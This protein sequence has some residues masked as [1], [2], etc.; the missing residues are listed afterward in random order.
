MCPCKQL[1]FTLMEVLVAVAI[2][3]VI[4]LGAWQVISSVVNSR[5]RV[6]Q[7]AGQFDGLQTAMLLLERDLAQIVN[8]PVRDTYGDVQPALTTRE[9]GFALIL[10]RQGW[11]NPL[12]LR[13]SDLQ[14]AGWEYTGNELSR[15]YWPMVDQGQEEQGRAVVLLNQVTAFEIRFLDSGGR[16]YQQ[17]PK[18]GVVAGQLPGGRPDTPLPLGIEVTLEHEQFGAITRTFALPDFHRRRGQ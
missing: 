2:T 14:R 4:G 13:R 9:E 18:D 11:R 16:E 8:R 17:W 1:G 10:T 3:A 12:G 7:V 5:E 15:H 6:D